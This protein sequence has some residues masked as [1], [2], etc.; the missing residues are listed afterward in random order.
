[1]KGKRG[2]SL[3]I[4]AES[5]LKAVENHPEHFKWLSVSQN[6]SKCQIIFIFKRLN[7]V[8]QSKII[9]AIHLKDLKRFYRVL[10]MIVPVNI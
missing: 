2:G 10:L 9:I 5:V 3:L 6:L 7:L 8:D 4:Q 1:M